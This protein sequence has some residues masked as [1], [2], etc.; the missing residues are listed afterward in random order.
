MRKAVLLTGLLMLL[1]VLC[2]LP[3]F[4][5]YEDGV[6][7]EY[8]GSWRYDDWKCDNGD[9]CGEGSGTSCYEEHHCGYCGACDDDHELC[10]DCGNC[11]EDH[12]ECDEKCRGCYETTGTV[13]SECGEKCSECAEWICDDCEKCPDCAGNEAYCSICDVCINCAEWI[14]YCGDGCGR[15]TIGCELCYEKCLNCAEDEMCRE[16]GTCFD[17]VGGEGNYCAD[18]QLCKFCTDYICECG[19]GCVECVLICEQCQEKCEQCADGGICK[20]CGTCYDC[21]GGEGNY[22][23]SCDLCKFCVDQVCV[24]CSEGC[25]ACA[26]LCPECNA[27]CENCGDDQL[28]GSCGVCFDC[29]GGEGNYCAECGECKNCV[30]IC[31]CGQGCVQ[32]TEICPECGEKCMRCA[33]DQ[34]CGECGICFDCVGGEGNYC[35]DCGMCKFCVEICACGQGCADCAT[36]CPD[37]GE[38]CTKCAEEEICG[39]CNTC[40]DCVGG[41]GDFCDNCETCK[42]CTEIVCACGMGCAECAAVCPECGEKCTQCADGELCVDCGFCVGCVGEDNFC[43]TCLLCITCVDMVCSCGGG[44]TNC[45]VVCMECCEACSVCS[46]EVCQDCGT[47]RDCAGAEGFCAD[48]GLC[49]NC[50]LACPCGEGCENCVDICPDCLEKCSSCCDEF[51]AFCDI[52]R[53]CAGDLYC[54]DC[55]LCGN[56]TDICEECGIVCRDCA[57]SI[58]EDCGKCS[59]CMDEFCPDCGKCMDCADG[60]CESCYYCSDCA[61]N[62]CVGCGNVC[63]DCG[64]VCPEC[65]ICENCTEIC[66]D[67]GLCSDCCAEAAENLGCSHKICPESSQWKQH[68]CTQGNHCLGKSG[69][70]E[71]DDDRHWMLCGEGCDARLDE[72][73]H[74]FGG[75]KV[76]KEATKKADG[77]MSFACTVCG[78]TKEEAIPKL[79]DGH[80]HS[81]TAVVTQP[82]CQDGGYTTHTCS[83]GHSWTDGETPAGGHAYVYRQTGEEH[84]QECETCRTT[85]AR[86]SHKLGGWVTVKKAGYTFDGEKQRVCVACGY[87][88]SQSIPRLPVPEDKFVVTIPDFPVILP[89]QPSDGSSPDKPDSSPVQTP[90]DGGSSSGGSSSGGSSSSGASSGGSASGSSN[91]V[92]ELLTKGDQQAVPALPT[93]PPTEEGNLFDGWVNQSTGEPV[94]KGDKLTGNITIAPVWKDCGEGNHADGD[95]DDCCDGCGFILAPKETLPQGGELP[96]EGEDEPGD[97]EEKPP[98]WLP[99]TL[100]L[101]AV[102]V[103]ICGVVLIVQAVKQKAG[104]NS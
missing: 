2:G 45:A 83:C 61:D 11:L 86:S 40:K 88:I 49:G 7:C 76:V 75:G 15:C 38:K 19:R 82:T 10:D 16:C 24:G 73:N 31:A 77:V 13:C 6:E 46:D 48:C 33:D 104:R 71:F 29:L 1:M 18:C 85:T 43:E 74:R 20:D 22:C 54:E 9:H 62:L 23:I 95:G 79:T 67:C 4:A 64:T 14:C 17:C 58:C 47:C 28:C 52:C 44:C 41:E 55:G 72:E 93:L 81:Y 57:E 3:A 21:V 51:C 60:M 27:V 69:K 12:C 103:V 36:I 26:I 98:F 96:D 100:I 56:C 5:G 87:A 66:P 37:C 30:E 99:L 97:A 65:M 102:V 90:A 42:F 78:Y 34:L 25:S 63:S 59:G 70:I 101:G 50:V 68:F 84:W 39:G 94:K 92:K 32:C 53:D 91:E 80:T 35:A 8:C 89:E